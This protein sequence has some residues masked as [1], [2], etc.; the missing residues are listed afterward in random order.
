MRTGLFRY[1][2]HPN[3]F[4]EQ[5]QWWVLYAIGATAAVAAGAGVW[6]GAL[7]LTIA[8]PVL[9]TILFLGSTVFTESISAQKYPDYAK[10]QRSTSMLVPWPPRQIEADAVTR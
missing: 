5:A 10:Y 7:N 1:S 6:G 9:L 4:F 8:G 3:F 2:R